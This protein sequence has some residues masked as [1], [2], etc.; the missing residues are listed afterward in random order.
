MALITACCMHASAQE[1]ALPLN[2]P[3]YNKP[4]LFAD[5]PDKM[6]LRVGDL[7]GLFNLPVGKQITAMVANG[8]PFVGTVISKSDG[9]DTSVKS[10]VVNSLTRQ[11]ATFTFTRITGKDGTVSYIGRMLSKA[12]GDALEIAKEGDQYIIRK[13]NLY[14]LINE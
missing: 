14:D 8:F 13:K 1:S 6:P 11:G 10:I 3:N 9:A 7:E 4:K 2:Q 12:N 5:L